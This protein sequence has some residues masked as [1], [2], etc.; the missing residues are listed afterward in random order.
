VESKFKEMSC[1]TPVNPFKPGD[2]LTPESDSSL[3]PSEDYFGST[4]C[5]SH[6]ANPFAPENEYRIII[7]LIR[8]LNTGCL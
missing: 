4:G 7:Q 3:D 2:P 1:S 6:P 5:R 8:L